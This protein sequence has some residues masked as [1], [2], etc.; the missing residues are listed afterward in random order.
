V[1]AVQAALKVHPVSLDLGTVVIPNEVSSFFSIQNVSQYP[2]YYEVFQAENQAYACLT[3][4]WTSSRDQICGP[5]FYFYF[6]ICKLK[7]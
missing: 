1:T 3:Y 5:S 4:A 7:N 6:I 2:L